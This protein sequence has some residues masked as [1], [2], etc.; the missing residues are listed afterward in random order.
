[1]HAGLC[2]QSPIITTKLERLPF[3]NGSFS[4]IERFRVIHPTETLSSDSF[5]H[6]VS[7]EIPGHNSKSLNSTEI[8]LID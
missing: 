1:M 7:V 4:D 2:S 8:F 3:E 5:R 6:E